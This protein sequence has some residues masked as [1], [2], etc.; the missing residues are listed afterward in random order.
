M[1]VGVQM[2]NVSKILLVFSLLLLL[3]ACGTSE[4]AAG[5]TNNVSGENNTMNTENS[6]EENEAVNDATTEEEVLDEDEGNINAS[7]SNN[8]VEENE[9]EVEENEP[10]VEENT[11]NDSTNDEADINT[12]EDENSNTEET[13]TLDSVTLFFSDDQLLETFRVNSGTSV[14]MD[15]SG[16]EE[17]MNLW[18]AGPSQDGLVKLLPEGVTVQSV[19]FKDDVAYV[20]FSQDIE[21]T[22]LGSS[23]ELMFTQHVALMMNQFGYNST[24]ILIDGEEV[25]E[26]LGHMDL[27]NPISAQNP[28][29]Y[30]LMNE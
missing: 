14:S 10:E 17:A 23:G 21:T 5:D 15:E 26:L 12:A 24:M 7:E 9:P 27:S 4:N 18:L 1:K 13:T 22:N 2:K 30:E 16:A 6:A 28:E 3:A 25:G 19:E 11:M 8:N 20:S 29:D